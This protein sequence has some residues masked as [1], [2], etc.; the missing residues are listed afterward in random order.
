M[1]NLAMPVVARDRSVAAVTRND[2]PRGLDASQ[3]LPN[4]VVPEFDAYA[5]DY[6]AGMDNPMK[7]LMGQSA[8][9]FI[10]IKLRW[11]LRAVPGLKSRDRSY[12]VLDYGCG[13]GTILR[14]MGEAGLRA[15]LAGCDVSQGML[16]QAY[17]RWPSSL[18]RPEL[19]VQQSARVPFGDACFD[20]AIISAVLHHIAPADRAGVYAAIHRSLR[21]GGSLVVFEHNPWNPVTRYVV[22]H[23]PIDS[24]AILL[25]SRETR[26]GLQTA[27]FTNIR[28]RYLMF[29]PPRLRHLSAWEWRLGYLPVGA[30]YAT[31]ARRG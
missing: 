29:F 5:H 24:N 14:L 10:Q 8:D 12:R 30:Q 9:D 20:L 18:P 28:T 26:M 4:P 11:L 2:E 25:S 22:A 17:Q 1:T 3:V 27:Q 7:Q 16:D 23:T 21:P 31:T 19:Q 6:A 13:T 15:T